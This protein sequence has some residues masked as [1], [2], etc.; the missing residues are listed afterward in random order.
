MIRSFRTALLAGL[1][2]LGGASATAE[3]QLPGEGFSSS[4]VEFVGNVFSGPTSGA[5]LVDGYLY[6]TTGR[7][8]QIYDTRDNPESPVLAGSVSYPTPAPAEQRAPHEDPDT[9]GRTLVAASDGDLLV[10]DVTDKT[11]P[12]ALSVVA[13]AGEHTVSCVLDCTYVFGSGGGITDIR[14]PRNPK[15]LD[16]GLF[17]SL[18]V[19]STHDVTELVH[20]VV[21]TSSEP[22]RLLDVRQD[23]ARPR[24]LAELKTPGFAHANLWP[25]RM[26]DDFLLVGGEGSLTGCPDSDDAS[27]MTFDTRGWQ[28]TKQFKLVS[29][30]TMSR[31]VFVDGQA[32]QTSF[33]V[34][35]FDT[36]PAYRNGGLVAIGWYESGL[37]F[38]KVGTDGML[39]EVGWYLP[40]GARTS[41][42]YWRT[43]RILYT[44]DYFRGVD[45]LKW[46]GEIPP[47]RATAAP[48]PAPAPPAQRPARAVSVD[49]LVRLP[50]P[51][52]CVRAGR[53]AIG[54]RKA[55]DPVRSVRVFYG[56]R[57]V[58]SASGKALRKTLRPRVLGAGRTSVRVVV[59]TRSGRTTAAQR[60]YRRC[61]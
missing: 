7:N 61:G 37:R 34:H 10:F 9:N 12:K 31:G 18:P 46:N 44:A 56:K 36:H 24:P 23:P 4:D 32:P 60:V 59:R 16:A 58:L 27:F 2:C 47:S 55:K 43:D 54:V 45:V 42:A 48:A 14:D 41:S 30:F 11:S 39:S 53:L 22:M 40:A 51:R 35:W 50:S 52:R 13:G 15:R 49:D 28:Q 19:S 38:L 6:V 21:M 20:G 26:T 57:R 1:L 33:C 25:N 29:Q 8:L 3:A 5:R 17:D